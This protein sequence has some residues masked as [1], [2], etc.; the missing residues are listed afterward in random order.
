MARPFNRRQLLAGGGAAAGLLAQSPKTA[1]TPKRINK[2]IEL[3]EM[4]QPIYYGLAYGGYDEGKKNAK[5]W[6][7]YILY[8]MESNPLDF[9]QLRDFMRGLVDGG[10]TPSGHRTPAVIVVLPLFGIDA[11]AVEAG[12]WM[13]QQALAQGVHGLLLARAR[14]AEAVKR[15]VRAVRYPFQK[16]ALDT[17]GYGTRGWG[18]QTFAAQI[19]GVDAKKYLEIADPWPLNPQGEVMLGLRIE[20]WQALEH[21]EQSLAVP[22]LAFAEHG[23]RDMGLSYGYLD[24]R[25]D[26][27]VPKEVDAAGHKVLGLCKKYKLAFLDNVLPENVEKRIDEG[28]MIGAGRRQDSAEKGRRYTKRQMPW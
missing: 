14:D 11:A 7:D 4:R 1:W 9:R 16:T 15:F 6:A 24:G 20:D 10:P 28:V 19:W 22:G 13:V 2:S 27:P 18:S 8:D 23:P 17:L 5:T 26:P 12:S 3:L 25:A 21:A